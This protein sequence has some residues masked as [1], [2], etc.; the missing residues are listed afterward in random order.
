MLWVSFQLYPTKLDTLYLI[1]FQFKNIFSLCDFFGFW[2][3]QLYCLISKYLD[4]FQISVTILLSRT[5]VTLMLTHTLA[6]H[7][8]SW[9]NHFLLIY[10]FPRVSPSYA[11]PLASQCSHHISI[12]RY[13]FL[14]IF[15]AI[16][17]S[18]KFSS[19]IAPRK[20]MICVPSGFVCF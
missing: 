19:F 3:L 20:V 15:Q 1:L 11:L 12:W 4:I 14:L 8:K 16:W 9:F 13:L 17:L 10:I 2:F 18:C 7:L 5:S 6:I